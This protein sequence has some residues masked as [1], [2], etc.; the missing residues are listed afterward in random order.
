MPKHLLRWHPNETRKWGRHEQ[1]W[2]RTVVADP[3]WVEHLIEE[4]AFGSSE[5]SSPMDGSK[6]VLVPVNPLRL[7]IHLDRQST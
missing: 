4:R 1:K 6:L 5:E 3:S 7:E 2:K